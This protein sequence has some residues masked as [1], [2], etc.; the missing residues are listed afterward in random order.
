MRSLLKK[1]SKKSGLPPGTLVHVGEQK[2]EKIHISVL[3]YGAGKIE[4]REITRMEECLD[5]RNKSA[6]TWITVR[7][8]HDVD[9]IEQIGKCF[10][11]HPLLMEDIVNTE[12]RPKVDYF[13]DSLFLIAR[14]LSF[15]HKD[16]VSSEQI[17][18]VLGSNFVLSFEEHEDDTFQR[19]RE[20]IRK[21]RFL[22][23]GAT[24][25]GADYLMYALL[26][27][28]VDNYFVIL[29]KLGE[30]IET[31]EEELITSPTLDIL[32]SIYHLKTQMIFLR[33]S[34][35]PLREVVNSLL[36]TESALIKKTTHFYLRDIYDHAIQ[37]IETIETFRDMLTGMLEIYLSSMSNR[38]N[39][40]MKT[41]TIIGTIFI[42]LTFVTSLYGMNFKHMPELNWQYGYL[43]ALILMVVMTISMLIYFKKRKLV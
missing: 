35:W 39:E 43:W 11:L 25:R 40:V 12:Q 34:V 17:S 2:T 21:G 23:K 6:V 33:R 38:L 10:D 27:A 26:D 42:P 14:M 28:I 29:E 19:I 32:R 41:L 13:E 31:L 18:I 4:E 20:R 24:H 30:R 9:V 1:R 22:N 8:V 3:T 37:V 16:I 15:N 5:L 36:R 7:G